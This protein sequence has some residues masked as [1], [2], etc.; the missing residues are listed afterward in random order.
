MRGLRPDH[1]VVLEFTDEK[2]A[3]GVA[4][5]IDTGVK[6]LHVM[7][8]A[9]LMS[10]MLLYCRKTGIPLSSRSQKR[11]SA[12]TGGLALTTSINWRADTQSDRRGGDPQAA[13]A[14]DLAALRTV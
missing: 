13:G 14:P 5:Q 12:V 10:A 4:L 1:L 3:V 2:G 6:T 11:L 7:H 8:A 9:D